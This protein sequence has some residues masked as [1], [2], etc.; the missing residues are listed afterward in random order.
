[1]FYVFCFKYQKIVVVIV[2]TI[3]ILI[4]VTIITI[5]IIIR[6]SAKFY[7]PNTLMR[8]ENSETKMKMIF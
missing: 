8:L 1:M 3:I 2:N 4:T 7:P 5:K 6:V